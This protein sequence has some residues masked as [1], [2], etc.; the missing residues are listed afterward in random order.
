MRLDEPG[1]A[2]VASPGAAATTI[3]W[4]SLDVACTDYSDTTLREF[5][6]PIA[7]EKACRAAG[8][9]LPATMVCAGAGSGDAWKEVGCGDSGGP[10]L[11]LNTSS[12]ESSVQIGVTSFGYGHDLDVYTRVSAYREWISACIDEGK[13]D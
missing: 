13:C 5:T 11:V 9:S 7:S 10:L 12:S 3:G 6:S 8:G 2:S 1:A 4:G